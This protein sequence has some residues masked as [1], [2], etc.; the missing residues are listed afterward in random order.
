MPIYGQLKSFKLTNV[1]VVVVRIFGGT[2]LG[3]GGLIHAYRTAAEMALNNI[4]T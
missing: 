4:K 2:K 1:L 3:V